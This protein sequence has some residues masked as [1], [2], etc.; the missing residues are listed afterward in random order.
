MR[1]TPPKKTLGPRAKKNSSDRRVSFNR[2]LT[3]PQRGVRCEGCGQEG[4]TLQWAHV[5]GRSG[6]GACLGEWANSPELT[7]ALCADN[8][9]VGKRGC[10]SRYD[11][12]LN[13]TVDRQLRRRLMAAAAVRI[14]AKL[15]AEVGKSRA[16][17]TFS[18]ERVTADRALEI[19]RM[20]VDEL[21]H[22]GVDPLNH[23]ASRVIPFS[24]SGVA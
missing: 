6:S 19:I 24:G 22:L 1:Y 20:T 17:V 7:T 21:V 16:L 3:D 23:P 11:L 8:I 15:R 18:E 2:I 9:M 13:R 10:H 4:V 12:R 5:A 14:Q